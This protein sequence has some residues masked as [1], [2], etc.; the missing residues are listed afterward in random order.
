MLAH[1][2]QTLCNTKYANTNTK[3]TTR[4]TK[5]IRKITINASIEVVYNTVML[6]SSLG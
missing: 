5:N 6:Y 3:T 4:T 1:E 2:S